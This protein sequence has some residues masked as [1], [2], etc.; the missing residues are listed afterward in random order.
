[1]A[2]RTDP[3]RMILGAGPNRIGRDRVRLLLR[4]AAYAF[5]RP[6]ARRSWSTAPRDGLDRLRHLR[7]PY[8]EPLTYEDLMDIRRRGTPDGVL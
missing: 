6:A 8:F 7:P 3:R 4:D 5:L 2:R 1:M